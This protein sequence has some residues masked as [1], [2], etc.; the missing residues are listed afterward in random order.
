M[1]A[2]LGDVATAA[3]AGGLSNA[4]LN[5][6]INA[7]V[8]ANL[9]SYT[10]T[11][12]ETAASTIDIGQTLP[13]G[14]RVLEIILNFSTAQT[15]LTLDIGDDADDDRY[16]AASTG[17]QTAGI[18]RVS[19]LNYKTGQTTGDTQIL[20]TTAAATMTAGQL[21]AIVLFTTD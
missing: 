13:S 6:L 5:G 1:A 7:R 10:I 16:G 18:T 8:K 20:L 4:V 15:S 3:Q 19:G 9:E 17:P 12:S 21:E 11:G 14:A 2:F